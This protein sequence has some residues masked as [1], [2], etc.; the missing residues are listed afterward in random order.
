M[1]NMSDEEKFN[2]SVDALS[3]E[4]LEWAKSYA[5]ENGWKINPDE[6][7]LG[8]VVKG[9][10]RNTLKFGERYCPCRIRSGDSEKDKEIICPCIY[11]RD[12]IET[13]GNCHCHLFYK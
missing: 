6:K 12:E 10:A 8:A 13:D 7:Q 1:I 11:H 4:I 5:R 2:G 9:L 3:E